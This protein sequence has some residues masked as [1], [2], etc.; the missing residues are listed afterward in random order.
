MLEIMGTL[1]VEHVAGKDSG[2]GHEGGAEWLD[3]GI[4][5]DAQWTVL[6]GKCLGSFSECNQLIAFCGSDHCLVD[7]PVG[8]TRGASTTGTH[9]DTQADS[10]SLQI[11]KNTNR[12]SAS[13]ARSSNIT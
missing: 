3:I 12:F 2:E 7:V 9:A 13:P 6:V 11:K 1:A 5:T 8:A 10:Q 4:F